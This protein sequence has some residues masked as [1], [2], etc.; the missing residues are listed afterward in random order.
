MYLGLKDKVPGLR[1]H[2]LLFAKD[3]RTNFAE[4]FDN[5]R[6]PTDPSMYVCAP[7][8]T[9]E[10][11]APKGQE[12][13][14]ILVP[15]AP[16]LQASPGQLEAYGQRVLSTLERELKIPDLRKRIVYQRIFWGDDFESRYNNYRGSALGLAHTIWQTAILRPNN[17]SKKLKN[18]YYVGANTN[19]GIGMP[20]CLISAELAYK[21]IIG[22]KSA[23]HLQV[24]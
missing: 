21:R 5:P 10:S 2:N 4:I 15:T 11:I 3:W 12:N 14:F 8:V 17:V 22:D 13:L 20:I 16:G 18:L 6:W 19:P 7:S 1:H 23:G 24:L 9:A